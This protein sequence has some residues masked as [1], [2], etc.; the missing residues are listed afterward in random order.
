MVAEAC[1]K[2]PQFITWLQKKRLPNLTKLVDSGMTRGCG[3]KGGVTPHTRRP[4]CETAVRVPMIVTDAGGQIPHT[5][6]THN[7]RADNASFSPVL[8]P[9]YP[10]G[11]SSAYPYMYPYQSGTSPVTVATNSFSLCQHSYMLW[12]P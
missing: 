5:R 10:Y 11:Y 7:S 8:S 6:D 3:H 12:L 1:G 9:Y 2:L 4:A